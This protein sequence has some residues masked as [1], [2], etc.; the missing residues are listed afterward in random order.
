MSKEL[1]KS[2]STL[3]LK[4]KIQYKDKDD[5]AM[6][7]IKKNRILFRCSGQREFNNNQKSKKS[8]SK[9]KI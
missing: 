7:D 3:V 2:T 9:T 5:D 1:F 4:D 8:A 6:G